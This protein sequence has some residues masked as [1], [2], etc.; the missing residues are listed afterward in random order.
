MKNLTVPV[1]FSLF[2]LTFLPGCGDLDENAKIPIP[3]FHT[4][5]DEGL[6]R[7]QSG[8][9]VPVI[10]FV[11]KNEIDVRLS[12]K[13]TKKPYHYIEAIALMDGEK[14]I[15]VKKFSFNLNEPRA[16]FTLPDPVKGNYRVLVKCNLHD[17]WI[18]PVVLPDRGKK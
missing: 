3:K 8:T 14:Q 12:L 17:M 10:E 2:M 15:D 9:H 13:P 18:A 1:L 5:S 11:S 4:A 16:R 7:N 6:W